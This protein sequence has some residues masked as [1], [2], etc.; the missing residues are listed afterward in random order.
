MGQI[1]SSISA[2]KHWWLPSPASRTIRSASWSRAQRRQD[3]DRTRQRL[4][5]QLGRAKELYEWGDY[6]RAQYRARWDEIGRRLDSLP[7][8]GGSQVDVLAK[9]AEFLATV[10]GAWRAATQEQRSKLAPSLLDEVWLQDKEVV[11]VKPRSELDRFFPINYEESGNG[12][13]EG[14]GLTTVEL[15]LKQRIN[16][17]RATA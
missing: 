17:L 7:S 10:P 3:T 8:T 11:A 13:I 4:E 9:L 12:D 14:R 1:R 5:I 15:H 16:V 6:T 2:T